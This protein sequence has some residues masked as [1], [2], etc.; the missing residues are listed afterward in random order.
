MDEKN[1]RVMVSSVCKAFGP[2]AVGSRVRNVAVGNEILE[3]L[4]GEI[5]VDDFGEDEDVLFVSLPKFA[6]DVHPGNAP[7]KGYLARDKTLV[8]HRGEE[9]IAIP[10]GIAPQESSALWALV[11]TASK[12]LDDGLDDPEEVVRVQNADYVVVSLLGLPAGYPEGAP[13]VSSHRFV[14]KLA[15]GELDN[16]SAERLRK[17]A[18]KVRDH[19]QSWVLVAD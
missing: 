18:Q 17:Y 7:A 5:L 2:A 8:R 15:N 16:M 14:R 1:I 10:R 11:Y 6:K 13:P 19:E 4:A 12:Y 3:H 9:L